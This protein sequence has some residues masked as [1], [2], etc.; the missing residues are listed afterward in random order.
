MKKQW[1][2]RGQRE[3]ISQRIKELERGIV[4]LRAGVL[5]AQAEG[6]VE[7]ENYLSQFLFAGEMEL[8]TFRSK[9]EDLD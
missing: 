1:S 9:L 2:S 6:D 8:E 7:Q 4:Q 5:K 3:Q